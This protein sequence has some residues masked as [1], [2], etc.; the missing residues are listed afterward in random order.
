MVCFNILIMAN[1]IVDEPS[2]GAIYIA[3][4]I[5]VGLILLVITAIVLLLATFLKIRYMHKCTSKK[6]ILTIIF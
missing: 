2:V 3:G 6:L 1:I 4:G 5:T